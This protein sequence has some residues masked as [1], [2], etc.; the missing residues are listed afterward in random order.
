MFINSL[1]KCAIT[2][3]TKLCALIKLPEVSEAEQVE[4]ICCYTAEIIHIRALELP[5]LA[6][7]SS[8]SKRKIPAYLDPKCKHVQE[9]GVTGAES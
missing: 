2:D 6:V 1:S 3:T 5:P 7:S 4:T 8:P 9:K